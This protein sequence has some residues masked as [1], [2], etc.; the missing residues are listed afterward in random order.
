MVIVSIF[1]W[2]INGKI[3]DKYNDDLKICNKT[4]DTL[5]FW[6]APLPN[7]KSL[8]KII[9]ANDFYPSYLKPNETTPI[10]IGMNWDEWFKKIGGK[11]YLFDYKTIT[12]YQKHE[13]ELDSNVVHNILKFTFPLIKYKLDSCNW[14][15]TY[16]VSEANMKQ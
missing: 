7:N 5:C 4:N 12:K 13:I 2:F 1:F 6:F 9:K 10:E 14:V 8:Y 3:F 15:I 11:M 16:E